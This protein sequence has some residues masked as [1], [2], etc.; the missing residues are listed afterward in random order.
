MG[1]SAI[2]E[3][4]VGIIFVYSLLSILVT[5]INTLIGYVTNLRAKRLKRELN[6]LLSDPVVR[7]RIMTHPLINMVENKLP[8]E[9]RI[10]AEKALELTGGN[11]ANVSYISQPIFVDVLVDVLTGE[12]GARLFAGLNK[13]IEDMPATIQKSELRELTRKIQITGEG[14]PELRD[15]IRKI[16]DETVRQNILD[17]LHMLENALDALQV[18]T[19][20]LIPLF[21]GVKQ[22]QDA[23]LQRSLEAVLT[24][25]NS[26]KDARDKIGLWFD[27]SM[28][29]ASDVF[30]REMQRISLIV[31]LILA[32]VLNVDTVHLGRTLWEDPAL[33][34]AVAVTAEASAPRLQTVNT[35][36]NDDITAAMQEA[37]GTLNDL[38]N[39]RLPVGWEFTPL[40][41]ESA[42]RGGEAGLLRDPYTD[43]RNL[44][45]FIPGNSPHWFTLV[46]QKLIGLFITT[47]AVAQGA[48][49][50]FDIL[51][52]LTARKMPQV[53]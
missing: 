36:N 28:S 40:T 46:L 17:A 43:T 49:F 42:Q 15:A 50:W 38:L 26:L 1:N 22:I 31:G 2:I 7:A 51:A 16:S 52:K 6:T 24:T 5:Q 33:R 3:V 29:R 41:S 21:L 19:S 18:E 11:D 48:P 23:Y 32:V 10:T 53:T 45:N 37:R 35:T 12:R 14:V 4:A 8:P 30:R 47:I 34:Q 39:L 20:D 13:A 27:N 44:W 9:Q 25:A